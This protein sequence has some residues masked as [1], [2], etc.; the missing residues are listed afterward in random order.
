MSLQTHPSMSLSHWQA[1]LLADTSPSLMAPSAGL[2][3]VYQ[4]NQYHALIAC[5]SNAYA[6]CKQVL[7]EDVFYSLV[8][9]YL[10]AHPLNTLNLNQYGHAFSAW[11]KREKGRAT[12]KELNIQSDR[13]ELVIELSQAQWHCHELYY[14]EDDAQF[15]F[16]AYQKLSPE[17]AAQVYLYASP[18][19]MLMQSYYDLNSLLNKNSADNKAGRHTAQK[20]FNYFCI[21]KE[22]HHGKIFKLTQYQFKLLS[23]L[24]SGVSIH[25]ILDNAEL[26]NQVSNISQWI[27]Q[28][29]ITGFK[30]NRPTDV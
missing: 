24:K 11:L 22:H 30:M 27:A 26:E 14:I 5:M 2:L 1:T 20:Q 23:M 18:Q 21:A 3:R 28:G 29:W 19:L 9:L 25:Q 12:C 7:G 8:K 13:Y 4:Q 6:C 17:Q 10:C 16:V 15:D